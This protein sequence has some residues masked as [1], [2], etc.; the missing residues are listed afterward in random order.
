[1]TNYRR[2]TINV[3]ATGI[4]LFLFTA[5]I[6]YGQRVS[7]TAEA[8]ELQCIDYD[9]EENTITVNCSATFRDVIQ[10]IDDSDI[11]ENLGNG[12]Y[13]LK[14]NLEVADGITFEMTSSNAGGADNLQYLKL[15][16]ENGIIVYGQILIDSV[17]ITSW[18]VTDDD[19]IEQTINGTIRRGFIQFAGSEGS[20][21]LNS[22]FGYLGYQDSGRRGFDLF[23]EGG[24]H[25]MVIRGSKFHHMWFAFYSNGA[26][27]IVVDG[28]EYYNNIKYALDPHTG[29]HDMTITN[30][31]VHHNPLGIICSLD[32]YNILIEG[33][34][35][36]HNIDY[37]IFFSRNMHDSIARNNHIY[38][39]S[40][41]ITVAESPNNQIY[42]NRIEGITSQAIRLFN[43]ELPDDG[44]TEGNLVYNN[45][46]TNSENGIGVVRSHNNILESN[47]FSNIESSEYRLSGGSSIIIRGQHFD[48]ALISH[49]GYAIDSHVEIVDS[50]Q[51][52]VREGA[53]DEDEEQDEDE[54]EENEIEG[55]SYNT[56]IQP[57]RRTLSDGDD[58]TINNSS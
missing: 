57:Y 31:W 2:R 18:D 39:S 1:M 32:C 13:I 20:Q 19:V 56:D 33:N 4:L 42:N 45:I 35:V 25:D 26:Y 51:I 52:E 37:G 48:N 16:S 44:L 36:E 43:P 54:E 30:N 34:R 40:I 41:G 22:D 5:L 10:T 21:I 6:P 15:A 38:N 3:A 46:I 29:T 28:N 55:D 58:I 8:G 27:N 50:G 12:E 17:K 49:E 14:A 11:L 9:E 47:T 7:F 23:G 24:S 53:I